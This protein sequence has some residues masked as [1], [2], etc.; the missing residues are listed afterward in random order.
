MRRLRPSEL[1]VI[2]EELNRQKTIDE[3][4]DQ[5][6]R[7]NYITAAVIN[8]A[9][10]VSAQ[11]AALG[12]KRRKPKLVEPGD[13]MSKDAKKLLERLIDDNTGSANK[14]EKHIQEAK[15]KR[16]KGPWGD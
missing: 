7:W 8:G 13:L 5:K 16:L 11:I 1:A 6:T 2:L 9:A 10:V 4:N 3:L 14:W 15:A 12:G